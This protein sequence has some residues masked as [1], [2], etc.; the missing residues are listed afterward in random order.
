VHPRQPFD[1]RNFRPGALRPG[2]PWS[3]DGPAREGALARA[4]AGDAAFTFLRHPLPAEEPDV[5]ELADLRRTLEHPVQDFLRTRLRLRLPRDA[6]PVAEDLVVALAPLARWNVAERLLAALLA[7][8]TVDTWLRREHARGALPGGLL[9]ASESEAIVAIVTELVDAAT[10]FGYAPGTAVLEPVDVVLEDGTRVVGTVRDDRATRPGPVRVSYSRTQPKRLLGPWLDLVALTAQDPARDWRA[11]VVN[12]APTKDKVHVTVR[13]PNGAEPAERAARARAGLTTAV[14]LFRRARREPI[15][16]F[17]TLARALYDGTA[18][19]RLWKDDAGPGG[20][21]RGDGNDV[22]NELVYGHL[23]YDALLGLPALASDPPGDR[24]GRVE[25]YAHHLWGAV[26]ASTIEPRD[27]VAESG[28]VSERRERRHRAYG[29]RERS[30]PE[31]PG[32]EV[33]ESGSVSERRERRHRA[34]GIRERSGP[35]RPG[36]EVAESG[37]PA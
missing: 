35:E 27:E 2:G 31:R 33:A 19:R 32:D 29:I 17:P 21:R 30:G 25:R 11:V 6:E 15:P 18:H 7:G 10:A 3:F 14:D 34:Y 20:W 5:V 16:L 8:S 13:D 9:G 23:D 1:E 4:R 28:S 24:T 36:D 37:E 22:A 26:D 12:R